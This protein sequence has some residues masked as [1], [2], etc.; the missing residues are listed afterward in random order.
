MKRQQLFVNEALSATMAAVKSDPMSAGGLLA[1][2]S[3]A[4]GVDDELDPLAAA[5]TLRGAVDDGL[6]TYSMPVVG[7]T[8]D[9]SD[10]LIMGDGADELLAY[11]AGTGPTPAAG[12]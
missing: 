6:A 10:V 11:F 3:P 5:A 1:A 2:I 8:I 12:P 4:I 7:K 9:G